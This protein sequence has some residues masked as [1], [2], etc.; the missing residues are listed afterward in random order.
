MIALVLDTETTALVANR[1]MADSW[2][3]EIIEFYAEM[4]DLSNETSFAYLHHF[5]KPMRPI[6]EEITKITGID[7][8]MVADKPVFKE[9]APLIIELIEKSPAV[10]AHNAHFD[11]ECLD[12]EM[13][14]LGLEITW[15]RTICTVEQTIHLTGKRLTLSA[16]HEHLF[17]ERFQDAHRASTDCKALIRCARELFKRGEL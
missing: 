12:I 11:R 6:S 3:P 13:Q 7:A 2:L 10:I 16:L 15:P 17:G 5:I 4:V 8:A 9:L 1:T 14:R